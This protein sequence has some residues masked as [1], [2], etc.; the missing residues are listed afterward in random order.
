MS[1]IRITRTTTTTQP[2]HKLLWQHIFD[3]CILAGV[4]AKDSSIQGFKDYQSIRL[5][6]VTEAKVEAGDVTVRCSCCFDCNFAPLYDARCL[7]QMPW[8]LIWR[9]G[10]ASCRVIKARGL[11]QPKGNAHA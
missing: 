4:E 6:T 11:C 8:G 3:I 2:Y 5:E 9:T 10:S 7:S 1:R